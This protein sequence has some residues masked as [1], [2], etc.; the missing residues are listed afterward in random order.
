[1][2]RQIME[3]PEY[4]AGMSFNRLSQDK[5]EAQV[6]ALLAIAAAIS[7]LAVAVE[8]RPVPQG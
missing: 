3:S 7:A 6:Y 2:A 8:D 1:M 5:D 4:Y